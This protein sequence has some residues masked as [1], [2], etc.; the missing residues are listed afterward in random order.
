MQGEGE[1]DAKVY[2]RAHLG[3]SLGQLYFNDEVG[4]LLLLLLDS[5][6]V[7][8]VGTS[9][10]VCG[11]LHAPQHRSAVAELHQSL[12]WMGCS[13]SHVMLTLCLF[14]ACPAA[15]DVGRAGQGG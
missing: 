8:S 1:E 10:E 3:E 11:T 15:Q 13:I 9:N 7:S 5:S 4:R 14:N 2:K 6:S 12:R